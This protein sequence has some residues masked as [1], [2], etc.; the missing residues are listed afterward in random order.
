[1]GHATGTYARYVQVA[2]KIMSPVV[3]DEQVWADA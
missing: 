1:M 3:A 2:C